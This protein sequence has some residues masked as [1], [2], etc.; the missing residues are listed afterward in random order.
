MIKSA[1]EAPLVSIIIVNYNGEGY[2]NNCLTSV[3]GIAYPNFEVILVDNGSKDSS[4]ENA[5]LN[6]G[7]DKR[8]FIIK[9]TKNLGFSAGNNLGL[10]YTKGKYIVFLNSDT[11]VDRQ[12]LT[13]LVKALEN[14][15]TIGIAQSL[16]LSIDG[17]EIGDAGWLWS[18][19]LLFLHPISQGEK[20]NLRFAQ[21]FEVSFASGCSLIASKTLL[22]KIG[23]FDSKIQFNYDDTLLS[24]KTW[25]SGKRVVTVSA[26]K[27]YHI[28]GASTAKHLS[29]YK[30]KFSNLRAKA[31]LTFDIYFKRTNLLRAVFNQ[32]WSSCVDSIYNRQG[33]A[34]RA[35]ISVVLWLIR[36]FSYVWKNRVDHWKNPHISPEELLAKMVRLHV[37]FPLAL[38]PSLISYQIRK[39]EI[40]RYE[41]SVKVH[42]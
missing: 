2:L 8:L 40:N 22:N 24:F 33:N 21:I 30:V 20:P 17:K 18:D 31:L 10:K 16:I 4:I 9:S 3:L 41:N 13:Y 15:P 39:N 19:Y 14:D 25:L 12:W 37:D 23:L 1:K 29:S 6:F 35:N 38:V 27:T 34:A 11:T 32:F 26:A 7:Q 28:G 42:N 5:Q 36:N